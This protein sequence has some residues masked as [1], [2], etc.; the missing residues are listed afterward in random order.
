MLYTVA[1][2]FCQQKKT[3]KPNQDFLQDGSKRN[4]IILLLA[5]TKAERY[6]PPEYYQASK[7]KAAF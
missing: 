3:Y 4:F 7:I 6:H 5:F 1:A 2:G